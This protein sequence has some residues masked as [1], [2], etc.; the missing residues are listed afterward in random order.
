MDW[1]DIPSLSALRAFEAA[2]RL[3]SFSGAA[4]ALNVTHA[5]IAQHVRAL[6]DEFGETLMERQ[7]RN[8]VPTPAGR[9]FAHD[10]EAGFSE[11]AAGVRALRQSRGEGPISL[12]TTVTFAENW[13]MPRIARFWV[14]R[15]DIPI[16]IAADNRV[17]D[18][19]REGHDL[20][21]RYGRGDWPGLEVT[22]LTPAD[23]VIVAHPEVAARLPEGYDPADPEAPAILARMPWLIDRSYGEVDSWLVDKGLDADALRRTELEGN[24]LVLAAS[25]AGAGVS[26]HPRAV[27]ER[28]LKAGNLVVLWDEVDDNRGLGYY[29]LTPRGADAA[30]VKVFLDWLGTQD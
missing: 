3:E 29:I 19:R 4:R 15:P 27:V 22:L 25:R 7:G 30:K 26:M 8:M 13:L 6:E 16:T 24:N 12:T 9:R 20:A 18:L 1:R 21:I 10:L 28:D 17:H 14:E 23:T 2:A 11:I 5:A